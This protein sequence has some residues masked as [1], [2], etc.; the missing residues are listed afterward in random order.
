MVAPRLL[1]AVMGVW[2]ALMLLPGAAQASET[3]LG[4]TG[5]R[6]EAP[7]HR[8]GHGIMGDLPEWGRLC[9][10][11]KGERICV[12]LP[13]TR[14]FEDVAPRLAD[15]DHDAVP[16][17]VVVESSV[18]RGAAL[19][20]YR[21]QDGRLNR[22]ATPPI[23]RRNRWLAPV[24]IADLDGDGAVEIAY[25]DR[26][27]L[28]K[29]LRV[30]RFAGGALTHVADREGLTNH[31]IG[32]EV[33]PGGIRHCGGA[34]EMVTASADWSAVTVSTLRDG[35]IRTREIGPYTGP[36]SLNSAVSCP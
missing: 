33:I 6:F 8:Y 17:I 7:T 5:A 10:L 15:L 19:T 2:L 23:G 18:A 12:T 14:V 1:S 30:W 29:R 11:Q 3:W 9:L 32:W 21:L 24:G 36:G 22:I 31:R 28:A 34:P 4:S 35:R 25:I 16:E 26:P 27:H 20:V 13:E